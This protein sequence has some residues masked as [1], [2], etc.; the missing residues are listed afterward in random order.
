MLSQFL[1]FASVLTLAGTSA[2]CAQDYPSKSITLVVPF[3][4]GGPTD[5]LA[6]NLGV[7]LTQSLKQQIVVDNSAGAGGT[8][9]INK[10][11]KARN[12]GY[13]LLLMH[14][15]MSTSPALYRKLPYDTLNDFEYI[16]Q[17]ADVPMTLIGKKTLP[18]NNLKELLAYIKSNKEKLNY[19]NAGLGAASHLCGLL[20]MSKIETELTTI[21]YK[22]TA[23]AMTDLL[24][25]QVDLMCDQTTNTTQQIKAGTVK[26]YGVTSRQRVPSLKEVPTLAEQG[27]K[28]FEVVVWHGLYAPKGTP[29]PVLDKLVAA[30][31]AAVQ[32]PALKKRLAELGAEP[33]PVSKANPESLRTQL[34]TEIDQWGPIIKKAGVYAD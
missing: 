32:D 34:K 7:S 5:T 10:V 13:T 8:I 9:G 27:L 6:R 30:L 12:D 21:S 24:G 18:P 29:K 17:V 25:G 2:V 20:L 28:N 19:A 31:Q 26:V 33:V 4:A 1:R 16:G 23:P 22:G 15:G 3:A 14:I 11:A